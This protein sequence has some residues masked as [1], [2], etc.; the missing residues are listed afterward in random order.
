MGFS[1]T[2]FAKLVI[3]GTGKNDRILKRLKDAPEVMKL[4]GKGGGRMGRVMEEGV[5]EWQVQL[6]E[7]EVFFSFFLFFFLFFLFFL[8][9]FLFS[10][11]QKKDSG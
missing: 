4:E 10:P 3:F 5:E 7:E 9:P 1:E 6:P 11:S 2:I 8:I